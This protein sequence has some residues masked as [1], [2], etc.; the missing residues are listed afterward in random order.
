LPISSL[1][2]VY[3]EVRIRRVINGLAQDRGKT[4]YFHQGRTLLVALKFTDSAAAIRDTVHCVRDQASAV[5]TGNRD[6]NGSER[7]GNRNSN[8]SERSGNA[9]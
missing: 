2:F 3:L 1:P 4:V 9:F 6:S 8:G 7:N 5:P